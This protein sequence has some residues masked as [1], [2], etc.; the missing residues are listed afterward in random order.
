MI[1]QFQ[2]APY[3]LHFKH[4][5]ISHHGCRTERDG[6]LIQLVDEN[7]LLAEGEAAPLPEIGTESLQQCHLQLQQLQQQGAAGRRALSDHLHAGGRPRAL[8][9][10]PPEVAGWSLGFR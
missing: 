3:Q 7:G 4:P 6:F 2:F 8:S 9:H 1:H 10:C 5:W